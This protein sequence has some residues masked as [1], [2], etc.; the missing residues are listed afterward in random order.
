MSFIVTYNPDANPDGAAI[1]GVGLRDLT[2]DDLAALP[3]HLVR[4]IPLAPFYRVTD[5]AAFDAIL[6]PSATE[7]PAPSIPR[8]AT[9]AAPTPQE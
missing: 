7:P 5:P 6:N 2:A 9:K 1:P 3:A 4:S 8:R